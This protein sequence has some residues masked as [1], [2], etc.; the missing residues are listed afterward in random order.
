MLGDGA[1][2]AQ[3]PAGIFGN[4]VA[5][6]A[7]EADYNAVMLG[8]KFRS[9]QAGTILAATSPSGYVARLYSASGSSLLGTATPA[10][11]PAPVPG[12]QQASPQPEFGARV[13]DQGLHIAPSKSPRA[14]ARRV[15]PCS[16][17]ESAR[18]ARFLHH[19][20]CCRRPSGGRAIRGSHRVGR[21]LIAGIPPQQPADSLPGDCAR[22][23]R[24]HRGSARRAGAASGP[25]DRRSNGN[26]R[27]G[28]C[29]GAPCR[30]R[31][32]L[33]QGRGWSNDDCRAPLAAI[34]D[35]F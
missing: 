24:P 1:A 19:E 16:S 15:P 26:V 32:R 8:A 5:A 34:G 11:E 23:S 9:S 20:G 17:A 2:H 30:V 3:A 4:V 18:P 28:V 31:R 7:V 21:P 13:A 29:G 25:L 35:R 14:G 6:N 22:R 12:W 10:T 33:P 27:A